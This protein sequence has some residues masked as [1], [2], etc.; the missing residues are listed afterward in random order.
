V[1][2]IAIL[3]AIAAI[4]WRSFREV[5]QRGMRGLVQPIDPQT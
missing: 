3:L 1:I 2:M 4:D 5:R